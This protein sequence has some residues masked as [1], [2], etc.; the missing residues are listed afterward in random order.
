MTDPPKNKLE[1]RSLQRAR[2]AALVIVSL[3]GV[4]V[5]VR[6]LPT[7]GAPSA[8]AAEPEAASSVAG[9]VRAPP[10]SGAPAASAPPPSLRLVDR[11]CTYE[12]LGL[13]DY[14][15]TK[16]SGG[17]TVLARD[18]ALAPDGSYDL[19]LHFHGG[20]AAALLLAPLGKPI[21][22]ASID[23]GDSSGDYQGTIPNGP[24]FDALLASIDG[25]VATSLG[26][27][28]RAT[29]VLLSSFSA[30]YQAVREALVAAPNHAAL[31]GVALLDSLYGSY[32]PGTHEVVAEALEP[33][34]TAARRAL[35]GPRFAFLLTHSDVQTDGYATTAEVATV[36]LDRLVVRSHL[37][38]TEGARGMS[39]VAEERGFVVRGYGGRDKGAHCAH[40][41]LLPEIVDVWRS[42]L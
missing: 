31:T 12:D 39:R 26:R 22:I 40:L 24:A 3:V 41:A 21:V 33:F 1:P 10:P 7:P 34:E 2:D 35:S 20:V 42:K 15:R 25:A 6:L 19:V 29:R 11:D 27:P 18:A 13:G 28:A 5:G 17:T 9:D 14:V 4:V 8:V 30:G 37:V 23:R 38:K 16:T 32:R 36:L